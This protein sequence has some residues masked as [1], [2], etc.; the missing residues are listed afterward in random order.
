MMTISGVG[1]YKEEISSCL[2]KGCISLEKVVVAFLGRREPSKDW[3]KEDFFFFFFLVFQDRVS[4]CS[5]GCPGTHSVDQAGLELRNPPA[6]A[7]QVLELKACATTARLNISSLLRL[8][9][10]L[11]PS[12]PCKHFLIRDTPLKN[13]HV[14]SQE[15]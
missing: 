5:P 14:Y 15:S 6:S 4:L 11:P 1:R 13:Q 7:S 12:P 2:G 10:G 9:H 8:Y 3:Y